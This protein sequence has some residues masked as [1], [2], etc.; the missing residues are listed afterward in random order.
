LKEGTQEVT[1]AGSWVLTVTTNS[2]THRLFE[3]AEDSALLWRHKNAR[4]NSSTNSGLGKGSDGCPGYREKHNYR[5]SGLRR[6]CHVNNTN[7]GYETSLQR[8]SVI[9]AP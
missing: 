7:P 8:I 5:T 1:L 6:G 3:E 2:L 9:I 4:T